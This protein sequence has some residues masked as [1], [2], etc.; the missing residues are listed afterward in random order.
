MKRL[1]ACLA[2]VLCAG[3]APKRVPVNYN[4][5]GLQA[6]QRLS[7]QAKTRN[8]FISP[9]SIG[10]ALAIAAEGARGKT[11]D[12][13]LDTLGIEG[14]NLEDLNSTLTTELS[15]NTDAQ[16]G[17][18][19]A[20]WT[21]KD[22]KPRAQYVDVLRRVYGAQAQALDFGNPSAAS[23]INAWT[24][25]HTL[26]LIDKIVDRTTAADFI[27]LTNAL[28]FKGTWTQPFKQRATHPAPFTNA[29]GSKSTVQMMARD[30]EFNMY[31]GG[32][33]TSLR[34]TYGAGGGYAAFIL[35]PKGNGVAPLLKRLG[36][37][38]GAALL[39]TAAR[40]ARQVYV[41]VELP[42]FTARYATGLMPLLKAM[43]MGIAFTKQA[44]FSEIHAPPPPLAITSADHA[45]YV[46]VDEQGTTAAAATSVG[47]GLLA[48]RMPQKKF[49]VDHPFVFAVRD[50]HSGT[51]LFA[52]VIRSL[53][54]G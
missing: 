12:A 37:S 23:A 32:D 7:T 40:N 3:A 20:L 5:F 8:V 39:D 27:Y 28:A 52:G 44:D 14:A 41:H 38:A 30:G 47:V 35:L 50:E 22:V 34:M 15:Q 10:V 33:F 54:H 36:S 6:L 9:L 45:A 49:I 25:A 4:A 51:L 2:L 26:G 1:A 46:R 43:G 18:A 24:K 17:I 42:R 29:D 16:I 53:K 31:D 48:I 11:R 19:N 21:R 13:I